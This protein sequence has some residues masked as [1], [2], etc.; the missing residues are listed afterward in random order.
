LKQRSAKKWSQIKEQTEKHLQD[1]QQKRK[2]NLMKRKEDKRAK[3]KKRLIKKGR[4]V[5]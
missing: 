5:S 4:L 1:K 3:I 2:D